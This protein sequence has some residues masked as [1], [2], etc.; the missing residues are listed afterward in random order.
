MNGSKDYKKDLWQKFDKEIESW[1]KETGECIDPEMKDTFI[2]LNLLDFVIHHAEIS[3]YYIF[4]H[5]F[6]IY[7]PFFLVPPVISPRVRRNNSS[8]ST[9]SWASCGDIGSWS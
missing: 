2:V 7:R 3:P 6:F 5:S 1:C 8:D 4:C 9:L